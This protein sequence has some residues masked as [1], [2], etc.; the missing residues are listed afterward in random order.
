[1][2]QFRVWA[3]GAKRVEVTVAGRSWPMAAEPGGWYA[4]EA[5]G[6]GPGADYTLA[7][8]GGPPLPDPRS[9]WQPQGASGPSR[10]VDHAAF[11]WTDDG[12]QARPLTAALVYELHVGTFTPEG[13]F[14][15]AIGK[16]G[17]LKD[18]GATHIELMPVAEFPGRFGWGYDGVSLYA[19]RHAYGG[20]EGL[21]RLVDAAHARGLGVLLDVVY[22][23]LGPAGNYLPRFGPYFSERHRTP[24][25]HAL[26]F[27]GPHSG[28]VRRFFCDNALMWLRDYHL[29]GLRL[30][31]VHAIV[32]AS[33]LPFLEQLAAEVEQLATHLGRHLVL[34]AES[35]LNDPRIVRPPALGGFGIHAQWSDDFHHALHS[36]LTGEREGYYSDFGAIADLARA[37]RTAYVY[38]GNHST[39][40][41]RPHGRPPAGLSGHSFLGY[42]QNHDQI[43]NRARG[44]RLVHLV[45][46]RRARL[47][48]GLV[49]TSPFVP[50]LFQGEEFGATAPFQYFAD[51]P[52]D[53]DLSR[54]VTEGRRAEFAPFG[55][56]AADVPDPASPETF[57][58]SRLDWS[59]P[60]REPHRGLLEWHR[61]LVRL[62]RS[63]PQLSNG[64]LE[65]VATAFSEPGRWLSVERGEVTIAANFAAERRTIPLD[66]DRPRTVLLETDPG[67]VEVGR[68]GIS[69]PGEALAVLGP[70]RRP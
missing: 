15:G 21:K 4:A 63:L 26:N 64:N 70:S 11:R 52:D 69:L 62:R 24:W 36:V 56:A 50:M 25:G 29:D 10:L 37:L 12:F 65:H 39:F 32:D 1:M 47:A 18:L 66:A 13:T 5:A 54:A 19:P 3:P 16:L 49:L 42:A 44:E 33:A 30:D 43:G 8:D 28:E 61:Q 41:R 31:A 22:N 45:G 40:R 48:A 38:T 17:H 55:W 59:E 60:H 6:A 68:E 9:P 51:F 58:R 20:P 53:P 67:G 27:E 2:A 7:L 14:A 34:I 57:A 23:H 46:P 35:D